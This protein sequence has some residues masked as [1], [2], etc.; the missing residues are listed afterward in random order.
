MAT[1]IRLARESDGAGVAAIYGPIVENTAISFETLPPGAAE[2]TRRISDTLRSHPWLVCEVDGQIAGYA[3]A[4]QHRPRPAYR[5]SVDTSV[6]VD[7]KWHRRGAGR[8]LYMSLFAILARQGYG[9]AYAGI[10][11]PNPASVTLHEAV[12]FK[13]VGVY[14]HVGY[15]L[16]AWHD[17]GWWQRALRDR[18]ASPDE[19][20]NVAVIGDNGELEALLARGEA[21]IRLM[22]GP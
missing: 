6:Y 13:P 1:H 5:W 18:D 3:Y 14:E 4:S 19:P 17:V 2:M 21:V 9:N 16:G 12:G 8:G 20:H 15:K 11:L 7:P 22:G 10:A